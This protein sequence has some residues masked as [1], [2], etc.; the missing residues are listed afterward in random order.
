MCAAMQTDA[1]EESPPEVRAGRGDRALAAAR[2]RGAREFWWRRDRGNAMWLAIG[3]FLFNIALMPCTFLTGDPYMWREEARSILRSG[4]LAVDTNFA[5]QADEPG[6][7]FVR[8]EKNGRW[9]SKYGVMNSIMALPPTAAEWVRFG[10]IP[11][12]GVDSS[13]VIFN[14]YNALL[15]AVTAIVLYQI[16][17]WYTDRLW[18]RSAYVLAC[19]YGGFLWFY[20]RAQAGEI[21]Q[22]LFFAT[23]FWLLMSWV[24]R[25][26]LDDNVDRRSAGVGLLLGAWGV[27]GAL[28]LTRIVF[29]VLLPIVPLA[30]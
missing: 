11:R 13:I 24:R 21:Y 3:V 7:Y 26:L 2:D 19:L 15:A 8:N 28:V 30:V 6:Q 16:S 5:L 18:L 20:Q 1:M 27:F 10:R 12:G 23:G 17:R 14:M 9:Y 22:V 25:F 29:V 4:S